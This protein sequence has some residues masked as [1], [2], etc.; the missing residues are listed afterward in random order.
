M[1]LC[2][3]QSVFAQYSEELLAK[4]E[5]GDADAQ[6]ILGNCYEDGDGVEADINQ[7]LKY[8]TMAGEQGHSDAQDAL[9][10]YYLFGEDDGYY[11]DIPTAVS[12][13]ERSAKQGNAHAQYSMAWIACGFDMDWDKA[14]KWYTLAAD[15]GYTPAQF[16]LGEMYYRYDDKLDYEKAVYWFRK[17]AESDTPICEAMKYLSECY[18][19]GHG[20][21]KDDKLSEYWK[22]KEKECNVE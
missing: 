21:P 5:S 19:N 17:A 7:A 10:S 4:A 16:G 12:W 15:Q 1:L 13:F 2:A 8:W 20:V 11:G 6:Y 14:V 18:A 9:G 22:E 3:S